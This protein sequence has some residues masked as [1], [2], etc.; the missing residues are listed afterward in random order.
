MSQATD[1][2]KEENDW[3]L[4]QC[5]TGTVVVRPA[6]KVRSGET[7]IERFHGTRLE[8]NDRAIALEEGDF[9]E[10]TLFDFGLN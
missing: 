8:A 5:P 10:N 2:Y 3:A 7:V 1:Y 9:T 4:I 6:A